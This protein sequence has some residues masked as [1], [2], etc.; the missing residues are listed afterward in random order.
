MKQRQP[1]KSRRPDTARNARRQARILIG[2][3]FP[4]QVIQPAIRRKVKHKKKAAED[5]AG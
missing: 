3:V 1:G 5:E 4:S 2:S